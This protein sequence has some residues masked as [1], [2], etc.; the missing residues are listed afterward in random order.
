MSKSLRKV[1]GAVA[2]VLLL[3]ACKP[4][5][6]SGLIQP[7]ELEDLLYDYHVAQAM[8]ETG[9]DSMN[10]KRYSYVQAVF[11]K[12][13]V[14][15]AEFDSTMVWYASHATYLNDIYKK[16]QERYSTHVS[17]L[18]A[19]TGENDIFAHLDARGGHGQYLAGACVQNPETEF[20]GRPFAVYHDSR[21]DFP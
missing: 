9:G 5:V 2:A 8:A 18:G 11:E 19:S 4:G 15:E 17:A 7:E 13:G 16:L 12:H 6:P 10:F 21:Y 20:Y 1:C 14:S 3:S